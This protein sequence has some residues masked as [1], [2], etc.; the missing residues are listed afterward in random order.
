MNSGSWIGTDLEGRYRSLI[1]HR[2]LWSDP[3]PWINW[4][5]Y[6]HHYDIRLVVW[7]HSFLW[8]LH[9]RKWL[10]SRSVRLIVKGRAG[11]TYGIRG[12]VTLSWSRRFGDHKKNV[13]TYQDSRDFSMPSPYCT[14]RTTPYRDIMHID[15]LKES[16]QCI[17]RLRTSCHKTRISTRGILQ[18]ALQPKQLPQI[19]SHFAIYFP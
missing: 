1:S 11:G 2:V 17:A 5:P 3:R 15:V 13:L 16:P 14:D 7:L 4:S 6:P 10:D 18:P 8:A 19:P 12:K 9:E